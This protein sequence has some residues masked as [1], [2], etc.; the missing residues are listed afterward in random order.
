M[1]YNV[2]YVWQ[3]PC[4]LGFIKTDGICQYY[5]YPSFSQFGITDCNNNNQTI[6][7]VQL[8][9]GYLLRISQ[10]NYYVSLHCPFHYCKQ[11]SFYLNLSTPDLQWQFNR[12]GILCGCC[13]VGLS[14][15]FGSPD[16]QHCSNVYLLL[17]MPIAITGI[18]LVLLY[19]L[20]STLL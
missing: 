11:H 4:P 13:Q 6:L 8:T 15:V 7:Y 3:F 10:G 17:I 18:V 12:S 2:F 14:T 19:C 1:E 16:C 20:F 5:I 9:V